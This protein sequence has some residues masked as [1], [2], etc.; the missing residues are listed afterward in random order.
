MPETTTA[1]T[2]VFALASLLAVSAQA[3]TYSSPP[4]SGSSLAV[5]PQAVSDAAPLVAYAPDF[6]PQEWP[7]IDTSVELEDLPEEEELPEEEPEGYMDRSV[8]YLLEQRKSIS[9]RVNVMA[10]A[11]DRYLAGDR[12]MAEENETF[13]KLQLAERWIEGGKWD[14]DNDL[15]FRLDLPATKRRYRL[16]LTYRPD[17]DT[18]SL[19]DRTLPTS[20]VQPVEEEKSLF[21]GAVRTMKDE[22]NNWEGRVQG[23]IKVRWP[24]D[25]FVR[26]NTRRG[27]PLGDNWSMT[28][29]NGAAWF[30]EDG[31]SA[32]NSLAFDHVLGPQLLFRSTTSLQWREE[33][34]TLEMGQVLDLFHTLDQRRLLDY[35]VGVLGNSWSNAQV[36]V[37]YVSL[38]Y[39]QELYRNWLYLNV[40]PQIAYPREDEVGQSDD[41]DDVLSLLVGIELFFNEF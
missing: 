14:P 24:L 8:D 27:V 15:K 26:F 17:F 16:V 33:E 9:T 20:Q 38:I 5:A 22:A 11:I 3:D 1:R 28:V 32:T 30:N 12:A 41:F 40:V 21:A 13:M 35:Q 7:W 6:L 23:G 34:D 37:Y 31:F 36:N 25:P 19:A 18:E 4:H 39:R 29:R 10:R 2:L